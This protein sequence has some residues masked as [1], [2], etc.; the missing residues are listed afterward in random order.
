MFPSL[1][2]VEANFVEFFELLS[3]IGI[4]TKTNLIRLNRAEGGSLAI[5]EQQYVVLPP[6]EAKLLPLSAINKDAALLFKQF[7]ARLSDEKDREMLNECFVETPESDRAD[8][9]LQKLV[10]KLSNAIVQIDAADGAALQ[11]EIEQTI[12]T[13]ESETVLLVGNKGS[14]KSTFV[15]RFF[16]LVL[17][18]NIKDQCILLRVDLA[19]HTG[20]LPQLIPWVLEQLRDQLEFAVCTN[21]PPSYEDLQGIFWREYNR[22]RTGPYREQYEKDKYTFRTEFGRHMDAVRQNNVEAYVRLLI[23][24]ASAGLKKLPCLV[25]DNTDQFSAATQDA[26][27]QLAHALGTT[28]ATLTIV[29]ITDRTIWRLSKAGAL[30][31]YPAK[32]FYLPVPEARQ[33]IRRRVDF[34]N[35]KLDAEP[36]R[37]KS[38]F[39]RM[40]FSVE[41]KDLKVFSNAIGRLFVETDYVSALIGRLTN[42]D[43]RRMLELAARIFTSPQIKI[44]EIFSAAYG[45]SA[46]ASDLMRTHTA[47]IKGE[48]DRY[49]EEENSFLVNLFWTN[50]ERPTTPFLALYVLFLLKQ[51]V[52]RAD[53][54]SAEGRHWRVAELLDYFEPMGVD[55]ASALD[56]AQRLFAAR[57]IETMDPTLG[58]FSED[59]KVAIKDSGQAHLDLLLDLKAYLQ[60][61]ALATGLNQVGLR[62]WIRDALKKEG[63]WV[64]QGIEA[65]FLGYLVYLDAARTNIPSAPEYAPIREARSLMVQLLNQAKARTSPVPARKSKGKPA[66]RAARGRADSKPKKGGSGSGRGSRRRT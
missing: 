49:S 42:F 46:F 56:V 27:Y 2:A 39:S 28:A 50:P 4:N 62:D 31:S 66:D 44:D 41:L 59:S 3:S 57:A 12:Q 24:R 25:F 51:L 23:Y 52:K 5:S 33:I 37:A 11:A 6:A 63:N 8:T 40:G 58:V 54:P 32:S 17:P 20:D 9:D 14:G 60:Q 34:L 15:D 7:F 53:D 36:K 65:K 1:D 22:R 21:D 45:G 61:M 35:R 13:Q 64:W 10:E 16:N 55:R 48:Y 29:P 18:Q 38:Y 47:L 26:I 43:I 30:Q 19:R